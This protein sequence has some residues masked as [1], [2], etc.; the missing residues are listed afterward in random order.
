MDGLPCCFN[1]AAAFQLRKYGARF[2]MPW[3]TKWLQWGRSFSAA[4]IRASIR[5]DSQKEALQWGRSFSAAEMQARSGAIRA[6]GKAS[7]GPQLFSCGNRSMA[8]LCGAQVAL[9]W[10]RSFSA[11]EMDAFVVHRQQ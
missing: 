6:G 7:M 9:Q 3:S 2:N 1:G 8:L 11:A 5:E 10:G 4:E